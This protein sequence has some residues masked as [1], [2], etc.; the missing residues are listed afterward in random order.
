MHT[1]TR[2]SSICQHLSNSRLNLLGGKGGVGKTTLAAALAVQQAR[3]HPDWNV[4]LVSLDPA[5][6]L[7]D[8]LDLEKERSSLETHEKAVHKLAFPF[9]EL[10][11]L[12][13][14]ELNFSQLNNEFS[15]RYGSMIAS[16]MERGSLL[17]SEDLDSFLQ[18]SLPSVGDLMAMLILYDLL[19]SGACDLIIADTAPTGHTLRLL[20]LPDFLSMLV[21]TLN[22]LEDKHR[23]LM[24][25]LVGEANDDAQ[26]RVLD[27]LTR[28]ADSLFDRLHDSLWTGVYAVTLAEHL[29]LAETERFARKL[30][31]LGLYFKGI[32]VNQVANDRCSF[33]SERFAGQEAHIKELCESPY[34]NELCA[35]QTQSSLARKHAH[36]KDSDRLS[37]AIPDARVPIFMVPL[38]AQEPTTCATLANLADSVRPFETGSL[39]PAGIQSDFRRT[40]PQAENKLPD[41]LQ[42]G[43]RLVIFAG[44]GGVGKTTTTAASG[45]YLAARHPDKRI[46]LVSIDPAHSLADSL[47]EPVG[48]TVKKIDSNLFALEIDAPGLLADFKEIYAAETLDSLTR[49]LGSEDAGGGLSLTRDRQI[50]EKLVQIDSPDLDEFMVFRKLQQL[51]DSSLYDCIFLDPAPS[52]HL[53]RFLSLPDLARD[54]ITAALRVIHEHG[55]MAHSKKTV[56]ELLNLLK[57]IKRFQ[58]QVA[59]HGQSRIVAVTTARESVVKGTRELLRQIEDSSICCEDVL[60]NMLG[61]PIADCDFCWLRHQAEE[62]KIAGLNFSRQYNTVRLWLENH[63]VRGRQDLS[64]LGGKLYA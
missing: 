14:Q 62:E 58:C 59:D 26:H 3:L 24:Q 20:E 6:S 54:W 25:S 4:L 55:M 15:Q 23:L 8:L 32:F 31:G 45:Y 19:E 47:N 38:S 11:N 44:K 56:S 28:Q 60:V 17:T 2:I 33:C 35:K 16:V 40:F 48:S 42:A 7:F 57:A 29:S 41:F 52:G 9:R 43:L 30:V 12:Q 1:A 21:E 13:V 22:L 36:L 27:K 5:H 10:S 39:K 49:L 53:L 50:A 46:L 51:I 37:L 18:L 34:L 64:F 63:E 61:P